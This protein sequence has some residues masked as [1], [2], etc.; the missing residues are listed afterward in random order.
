MF[1]LV[2]DTFP[3]MLA[4]KPSE[5]V[6]LGTRVVLEFTLLL[7]LL[8][9]GLISAPVTV[10]VGRFGRGRKTTVLVGGIHFVV[11]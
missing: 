7:I 3:T 2:S 6:S 11:W 1:I 9:K 8:E 4:A 5:L 10:S